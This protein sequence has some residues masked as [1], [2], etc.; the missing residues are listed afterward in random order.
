VSI[1]SERPTIFL[2]SRCKSVAP[3]ALAVDER[4]ISRRDGRERAGS[5]GAPGF[6]AG[7][8]Q[9]KQTPNVLMKRYR[10]FAMK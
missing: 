2:P 4:A 7:Y 5:C 6:P 8:P 10:K 3:T 9:A 1:R